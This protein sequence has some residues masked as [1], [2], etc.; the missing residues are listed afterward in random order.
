M[1]EAHLDGELTPADAEAVCRRLAHEPRLARELERLQDQR[2]VRRAAWASLEPD[3]ARA[4]TAASAALAA[5]ARAERARSAA[6]LAGR[7]TAAAAVVLLAFASGWMARGRVAPER[8]TIVVPAS[9]GV[10]GDDHPFITSG[11]GDGP[12]F[13][14]KRVWE[15][16]GVRR[17]EKPR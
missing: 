10:H 3:A 8:P 16:Q 14:E 2:A 5:A 11:S 12:P 9:D 17:E 7:A 13:P 1:L 4:R 6:A 15:G